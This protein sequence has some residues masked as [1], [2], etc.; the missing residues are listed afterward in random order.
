MQRSKLNKS[1]DLL[2]SGIKFNE[3]MLSPHQNFLSLTEE[4]KYK[5]ARAGVEASGIDQID[6]ES[7]SYQPQV[8]C[9][10]QKIEEEDEISDPHYVLVEYLS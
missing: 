6:S 2:N 5:L 8:Q 4:D 7:E 9:Y 10:P 3:M 1:L